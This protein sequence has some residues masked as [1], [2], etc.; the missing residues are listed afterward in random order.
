MWIRNKLKALGSRMVFRLWAIMMVLVL[1][2]I[3]FMWIVQ[4]Y[5][6]EQNYVSAALNETKAQMGMVMD[7]LAT[8]DISHDEHLL[9]YLSHVNSELFL[10]RTDGRL[11]SMYSSGH[12]V[13]SRDKREERMIWD[14]IRQSENYDSLQAGQP[15]QTVLR[16]GR[17]ILG[18]EMGFPVTFNGEKCYLITRNILMLKTVIDLNRNQLIVLTVLLTAIASVLAAVL[19]RQFTRPI[20][21][22]K[23]TVDRLTQNDFTEAPPLERTDELG[24]LSH[25]VAALGRSLKRLDV[26]RK[27][28]I[29]NVSHELRSPLALIGGYAEMVRDITWRDEEKRN[30]D[31]NLIIQESNRMSRM[32]SDILDYSQLQAGFTQI[33]T[34]TFDL[35][36]MLEAGTA[37]YQKQAAEYQITL[38]LQCGASQ[39]FIRADSTKLNQVLRNLLNNALNHTAAGGQVIIRAEKTDDSLWRI[40]VSNPG[41]PI[42]PRDRELI[43]ERYQRSQHQSSRRMGTGIGLSI[44]STILTAHQMAYGVDCEDG[45]NSFWF[46]CRETIPAP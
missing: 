25:S 11:I 31:L 3:G 4:I 19:S 33:K 17:H 34:E 10:V 9:S 29:A 15:Y 23:D 45:W 43:W 28:V 1:F 38:T 42:P 36:E 5:L 16:R 32:V 20:L 14:T 30:E 40:S 8:E 26:L 22:I 35:K 13:D 6:F 41:P 39:L 2:G 44:V 37:L 24:L 46:K 18:Y 27:E 21:R 7:S 12:L